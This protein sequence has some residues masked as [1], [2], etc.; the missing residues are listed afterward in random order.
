VTRSAG[1]V[2]AAVLGIAGIVIGSI[3]LV[4]GGDGGSAFAQK[5]LTLQGDEGTRV[6]FEAPIV[7]KGHPAGVKAWE[8]THQIT[9]D[10]TGSVT[11]TC[12]PLINNEIDCVGGFQLE[13]GDINVENI[14][15]PDADQ[16]SAK[17]SILGGSSAYEGAFGSWTVN[18]QTHIYTLH[19]WL[20]KR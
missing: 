10:A 16:R 14:E 13:D 20:P 1:I 15:H 7:V 4:R 6:D 12:I 5:T 3:A 19:L 18:W 2:A 11:V 9:G 17:G 8:N